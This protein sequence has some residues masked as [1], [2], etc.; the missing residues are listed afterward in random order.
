MVFPAFD[1]ADGED[2]RRS[3]RV[4][5]EAR[6]WKVTQWV[7]FTV[8][9]EGDA[10]GGRDVAERAPAPVV[11]ERVARALGDRGDAVEREPLGEVSGK[12]RDSFGRRE[13][14]IF[15]RNRAVEQRDA[16]AARG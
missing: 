7:T 5:R 4:P 6:I 9:A 3:R 2:R 1:A 10:L 12:T 8:D 14:G 13:L 11:E 15:Q 16:R